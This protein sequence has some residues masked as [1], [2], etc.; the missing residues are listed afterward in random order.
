MEVLDWA[1]WR[2][3]RAT[4]CFLLLSRVSS[5]GKLPDI[6]CPILTKSG[7]SQQNFV[8]VPDIKFYGNPSRGSHTNTCG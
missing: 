3:C 5:S 8:E 7:T 6:F 2:Y 1:A 4:K